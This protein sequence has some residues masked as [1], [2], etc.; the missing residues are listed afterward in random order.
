MQ[1]IGDEI[2]PEMK[3]SPL[4][5]DELSELE[6]IARIRAGDKAAGEVVY[7]RYSGFVRRIAA[8]RARDHELED[9]V[10]ETFTQLIHQCQRGNGPDRSLTRY[11]AK[12][13]RGCLGDVIQQRL[14]GEAREAS[15]NG[16]KR[17]P[18]VGSIE[19]SSELGVEFPDD[20]PP[21]DEVVTGDLWVAAALAELTQAEMRVVE[22]YLE[23]RTWED[24]GRIL[25]QE[26][27]LEPK[28]DPTEAARSRYRRAIK[29]LERFCDQTNL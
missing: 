23:D 5:I 27:F 21:L 25:A 20:L 6:L 18:D 16:G 3:A 24:V 14:Q 7:Q 8:G 26:G 1:E 22:L 12:L 11:L 15:E 19:A 2:K 13:T 28:T 4:A 17:R 9:I 29:K 10:Q